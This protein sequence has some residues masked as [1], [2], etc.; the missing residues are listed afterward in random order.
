M[1]TLLKHWLA[2][3]HGAPEPSLQ[4][5]APSQRLVPAH[6]FAGLGSGCP[7]GMFEQVPSVA[8]RLHAMHAVAHAVLQQTPSAQ[9]PLT[10]SVGSRQVCPLVVLQAPAPLHA[11]GAM[12]ATAALESV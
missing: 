5:P 6:A 10:Q 7:D 2:S 4:T 12:Q 9:L 3:V 1:Q 8:A 11:F